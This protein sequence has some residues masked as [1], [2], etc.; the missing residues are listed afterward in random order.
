MHWQCEPLTAESQ[1]EQVLTQPYQSFRT[2]QNRSG[3][4]LPR[5]ISARVYRPTRH[6]AEYWLFGNNSSSSQRQE[7][8]TRKGNRTIHDPRGVLWQTVK[9]WYFKCCLISK[10]TQKVVCQV[11]KLAITVI[12]LLLT[13]NTVTS[14]SRRW[15]FIVISRA[16]SASSAGR[17]G[18][19][20]GKPLGRRT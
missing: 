17:P 10:Q 16:V 4:I 7:K 5:F 8:K 14:W 19:K 18:N 1:R 12:A 3:Y 15:S 9:L 20:W 2:E 13:L 11:I 6:P